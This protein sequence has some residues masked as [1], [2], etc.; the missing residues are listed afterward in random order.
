MMRKLNLQQKIILTV[1]GLTAIIY[2]VAIGFISMRARQ[3][4]IDDAI[5]LTRVTAQ[6]Y[7]SDMRTMLESDL[8]TT[9][10]LANTAMSYSLMDEKK[11]KEVFPAVYKE[12]MN[13]N[14]H[15]LSIWDSWELKH[16]DTTYKKDYGR[17]KAELWREDGEIKSRFYLASLTGDSP[18]Y[19]RI[20]SKPYERIENPY[21]ANFTGNEQDNKLMTSLVVP[22]VKE[23]SFIG[24]VGVDIALESFYTQIHQIRPFKN[25][26][27]FLLSSDL[28]YVA[29]HNPDKLGA[30]AL[31]DFEDLF[32]SYNVPQQVANSQEVMFQANDE[33]GVTSIFTF[34]P[35]VVGQTGSPWA[36]AVVVPRATILAQA[37]QNF[38]ISLVVG[39]LGLLAL[40]TIITYFSKT[41]TEPIAAITSMLKRLAK[42]N[43]A[44]DM[45]LPAQTNDEIGDMVTALNTTIEALSRKVD[46]AT[47]IGKGN[48]IAEFNT[49][50]DEDALGKALLEMRNNLKQTEEENARRT[51][52][53]R[54]RR[55]ANEG[56][57]KFAEILR[58][59][60]DNLD[61]LSKSIVRELVQTLEANQGGLFLLNE[62][63]PKDPYFELAAAMA[64]NRIKHKQ[65]KVLL[66]E[67]LIGACAIEKKTIVLTEIPDGYIEI[68]S[69][70]GKS[71]PNA[72]A[73]V[74]LMMEEKVLGVI[75]IAS[76]NVFQPF[77]IEFLEK[78]AQSIA[79]TITSVRV[80]IK[81]SELL[82]KTQ[83]QAEEML[84][85]EEEMRQNME[86]LQATQ[87]E[88][89]RRTN[90]MQNFIDA[91]NTSSLVIEY[92]SLGYITSIN[93]AYLDLLNLSRDEVIGTHHTDKMEL[94]AEKK[95][96]Y[97]AFW[98]NL[99]NGLPQKQVNRFTVHGKTYVFQETYTP[100]KNDKGD[101]YK[102]LKISNN[103]TSLVKD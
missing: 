63:D 70:L 19:A 59:D 51:E 68:T 7:A 62:D 84:A 57:A 37:N 36:L 6:K 60:N 46:F 93:D 27:A 98:N 17:Y 15:L 92:D 42:G 30:N 81:T 14:P 89:A 78:V 48:L 82:A 9:R 67:G 96:E 1:V 87:E 58:L 29:H 44:H 49:T 83:Q 52:E 88:S 77:Q 99:R 11:W 16:I 53:D 47:Q 25:S 38:I 18:A 45:K 65:K 31:E 32:N 5:A 94:S 50:S 2:A 64:Y 74:P 102:I 85:Q 61:I 12:A 72:L 100:I 73:I 54:Q 55:W 39:I 69:G 91:L 10:A 86:E 34:T 23:G 13:T 95:G 24:V 33:N 20:K 28:K 22:M 26:S 79:S 103:I 76:F 80:N 75:E 40:A 8:A 4:A 43:V 71:N 3:A 97:D 101:V 66:G 21:F 41:L 90:E 56:L 35:I